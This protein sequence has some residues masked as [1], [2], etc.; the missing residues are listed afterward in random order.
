MSQ[1][2]RCRPAHAARYA[3]AGVYG[4]FCL[5]VGGSWF[6]AGKGAIV[7]GFPSSLAEAAA[8]SAGGVAVTLW[9]AFRLRRARR[10]P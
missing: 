5:A 4:L 2:A 8:C 9:A 1:P 6:V 10:E 7:A 3:L